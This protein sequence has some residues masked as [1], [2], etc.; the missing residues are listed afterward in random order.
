MD[1]LSLSIKDFDFSNNKL[2]TI[3]GGTFDPPH[4]GHVN[5]ANTVIEKIG[6]DVVFM[7]NGNIQYKKLPNA[8]NK[9]RIEM[10]NLLSKQNSSFH[11]SLLEILDQDI[12]TTFNTLIK[13]RNVVGEYKPIFFLIGSDSLLS[14][15]SWDNW[16]ELIKLTNFIIIK[17]PNFE[18]DIKDNKLK[19]IFYNNLY[20][21]IKTFKSSICNGF[22]CLESELFDISSTRIRT[23]HKNF[24]SISNLVPTEI[25]EYILNNNLYR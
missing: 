2:Y 22:F 11:I 17:R 9:Q 16:E 19:N 21:D 15:N 20:Q 14:L 1:E 8:T 13:I 7:P 25:R 12:C 10:L 4:L 23:N 5:L 3:L 6:A 18:L 24:Q